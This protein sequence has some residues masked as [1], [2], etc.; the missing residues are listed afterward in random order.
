MLNDEAVGADERVDVALGRVVTLPQR[1]EQRRPDE[2]QERDGRRGPMRN[3]AHH[4]TPSRP[5]S[6][7]TTLPIA[8][9]RKVNSS[10][11]ISMVTNSRISTSQTIHEY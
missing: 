6:R 11:N 4:G 8:S 3:C 1:T 2:Q 10:V 9:M 7:P 5:D